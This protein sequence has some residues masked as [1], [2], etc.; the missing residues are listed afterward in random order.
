MY[1]DSVVVNLRKTPV[2]FYGIEKIMYSVF[3][4]PIYYAEV[5]SQISVFVPDVTKIYRFYFQLPWLEKNLCFVLVPI[6]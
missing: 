6:L 3:I 1:M 5:H 2:F 4:L